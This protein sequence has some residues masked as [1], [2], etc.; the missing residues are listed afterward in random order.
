MCGI[1]CLITNNNIQ[2]KDLF[3]NSLKKLNH[4]GPDSLK[5]LEINNCFFG[6]TRLAIQDFSDKANQPMVDSLGNILIFNGEIYNFK[7]LKVI[8]ENNGKIFYTSSDSEVLLTSLNFWGIEETL[9]RISGMFAFVYKDI[10]NNKIY[11][12]RDHFGMKPL[13]YSFNKEDLIISSEIKSILSFFNSKELDLNS[14]INPIFFTGLSPYRKTMFKNVQRLMP[15]EYFHYDCNTK[16]L[17]IEAYFN[18]SQLVD[19]SLYNKISK[20]NSEEYTQLVESELSNSVKMHTLSDAKLGILFSAGIDSS[21]IAAISSNLSQD[22]INLFKYQSEN[23]DDR[24]LAESFA[25]KYNCNLET[26]KNIDNEIIFELPKLIYHYETINKSD[27]T[28]LSKCCERARKTG[29]KVLLTGDAAD[30]IFGGYN[31]FE[32]FIVKKKFTNFPFYKL[33]KRI[34]NKLIPGFSEIMGSDLNHLISPFS[35]EYLDVYF[36]INLYEGKRKKQLNEY[37]NAYQFIKN[38]KE[39]EINAFLLDEIGSRLER[40]LIRNDR[41]GM[42]ESIEMRVPFLTKD[43]VR[44]AVNTP[45]KYKCK[46]K[47]SLIGK[48]IFSQKHVLKKIASRLKISS[49]II[50]RPKIGTPIGVANNLLQDIIFEKWSLKNCSLLLNILESD[51]K[52]A[53]I[54][55]NSLTEKNRLTWNMLSLE[56]LIREFINDENYID[57]KNEFISIIRTHNERSN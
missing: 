40:F 8:L 29:F 48:K 25:E 45:Y 33:F 36:D 37:I 10:V 46:F 14:S 57:L 24:L 19:E 56:I 11:A 43:I 5:Y 21:I 6:F 15:G 22:K 51:L 18:I 9:K 26:I 20:M 53:I 47:P 41:Y 55:S 35:T 1:L 34:F 3:L 52:Y 4:R 49:K 32:S 16:S 23:L 28:P 7:E 54:N 13:F 44:I 12:I 38:I 42:M 17:V 27:G 50:H 30:E 2:K 31:S 39:K